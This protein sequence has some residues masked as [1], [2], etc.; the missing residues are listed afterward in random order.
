[1][2]GRHHLT[3][4]TYEGGKLT[5]EEYLVSWSSTKSDRS[6]GRS[7]GDSCSSIETVP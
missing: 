1:M 5:L 6:P 2:E 7:F 3:F 4:E